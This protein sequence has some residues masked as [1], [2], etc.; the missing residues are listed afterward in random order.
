V[1]LALKRFDA[2]QECR[3]GHH[4]ELSLAPDLRRADWF[5]AAKRLR[6]QEQENRQLK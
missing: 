4:P 2:Y 6:Q 3:E 5:R 1:A